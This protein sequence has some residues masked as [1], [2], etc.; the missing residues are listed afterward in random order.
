MTV[1]EELWKL[2]ATA[3]VA[4]LRKR[5]I[6]PAD[7]IDAAAARIDAV[8]GSVNALPTLCFDRA[9]ARAKDLPPDTLLG[10]LP[11]AIK[12]LASVAGVRTTR[13]SPIF[14][15]HVP[16]QSDRVVTRLEENGALVVAKSNV[17][18]FAAGAN[19]VNPV[20]G[21]THNPWKHG[22]SAA[23]SSGGSAAAL[24]AGMVWLAHGNDLGGSLRTPAAFNGI[25]GLRPSV[26]RVVRGPRA[27]PF[28]PLWVDG[29]LARTVADAALMLD[30]MTGPDG[31][32]PLAMDLPSTPFREA[33][34]KKV[35]PAR[36]AWSPDLGFCD[37]EPEIV[38]LCAEAV[39][40]FSALGAAV[41]E[42][43]PDLRDAGEI[44]QVLRALT[45][46]D[47]L[48]PLYRRH[49]DRLK[50]DLAWNIQ[51]GLDLTIEDIGKAER[52]RGAM[53]ARMGAFWEKY[54]LLACPVMQAL[55]FPIEENYP[56]A[57]GGKEQ[58]TYI[59]WITVTFAITLTGCPALSLP[60]GLSESGLPV[61]VQL[62]APP[63]QEARLLSAAAALEE[64]IG[65]PAQLPIDPRD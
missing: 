48:G 35:A 8:N 59:D 51:K 64:L 6:E 37:V 17:P 52:A 18:E 50:P 33:V 27:L 26:G 28:D 63:R 55:P 44:F 56:K 22:Y 34:A 58:K 5:E 60:V 32:D 36:I 21:A 62:V 11:V 25:V 3:A 57:I 30:A 9:Y 42:A 10:G 7:L 24:A 19:T 31:A 23:G 46:A 47:E 13:G 14:A 53:I 40:G 49:G 45:L 15:D 43:A 61:G 29:P 20:F 4:L 54:D 65:F 1:T 38:A 39:A 41:E 2:T 16:K 12:D